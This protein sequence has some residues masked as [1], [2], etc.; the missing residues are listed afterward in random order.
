MKVVVGRRESRA[1]GGWCGNGKNVWRWMMVGVGV[2]GLKRRGA[3][4]PACG[5]AEEHGWNI[6]EHALAKKK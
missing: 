4:G 3:K 1:E 2:L 6:Q 5:E